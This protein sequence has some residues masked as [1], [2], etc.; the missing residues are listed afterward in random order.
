MKTT[1]KNI[2]ADYLAA[3]SDLQAF[4]HYPIQQP[5]FAQIISDKSKELTDRESL[6]KALSQQ[7]Q[8]ISTSDATRKNIDALRDK[9]TFTLTTGHQLVLFGGPLYTIYKVLTII[10]LAEELRDRFSDYQFVPVFWIHTEDHDFEEINHYY[11]SFTDKHTYQGAF[12]GKVGG[13]ILDESIISLIPAHFPQALKEAY[14]PGRS[15]S[16]AYFRFMNDLFK[17]YGLVILDAD[18]PALKQAFR[19]VLKDELSQQSGFE[20][21]NETSSRLQAAGYPLQISPREI[22][23]F[24]TDTNLRNR[25][26]QKN[27]HYE[28]LDSALRFAPSELLQI[29]EQQPERFSPNVCL[30]PLYQEIILPNLAYTGG[31]A[32]L[33]YW[34]QL[35]SLFEHHGVNFPLLLPRM[36]AT[37]FPQ[38]LQERWQALGFTKQD[39]HQPLHALNKKY[40]PKLW[41]SDKFDELAQQLTHSYQTLASYIGEISGTLVKSVKGQEVGAEKFLQNLEKKIHRV[42]RHQ[43]ASPF[44]EIEQI[45]FQLQP[46]PLVQER[47]WSLAALPQIDPYEFVRLAWKKCQPL[48][49]KHQYLVVD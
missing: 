40:I 31:W 34:M 39:I 8:G 27:G 29:A 38:K 9:Q 21:V 22:N 14:Q 33:A 44:K 24:Y 47:I 1:R 5:D 35:R 42:I 48:E 20:E 45:K 17:D 26:V 37:V 12:S 43:Y 25:I 23:L 4:Y 32:E 16:E 10:K 11:T 15:M 49:I 13:H 2:R 3:T 28:V 18:H 46:D 36:S 19:H 7:Y 41:Q 6:H 30:R